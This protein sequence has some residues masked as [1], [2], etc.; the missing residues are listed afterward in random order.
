MNQVNKN[1]GDPRSIS[2]FPILLVNF[3]GTMG[4]SIVLPFLVFLVTRFGGNALIFGL[5]AAMY[6]LFQLIGSP[7]LGRWSDI[8][9]R[10]RVLFLSQAGT[11]IAWILFLIALFIPITI[12]IEIKSSLFGMFIITIPLVILFIA[13][14][15]DG[16]TGGNVSVANAYVA[17]ITDEKMRSANFGKMAVSSNLG[18]I[19]G[20]ALAGLLGATGYGAVIPVVA[21]ILISFIALFMISILLKESRPCSIQPRFFRKSVRK[22]FGQEISECR[23]S[24]VI[25][26]IP[27]RKILQVKNVPYMLLMYFIIFLGF[28][29]FYTSFPIHS[30]TALNWSIA[31]LGIFFSV[32]SFFMTIVQ[33]PVLSRV[34]KIV[35]EPWLILIGNLILGTNFIL[36]MSYDTRVI[37]GAAAL[38][39]VGNGLMWPSV[40]SILS[41]VAGDKYQGSI[42]GFAG[43]V[44]SFSSIIGLII[45]GLLYETI[46]VLSFI[47]SAVCIYV[48][49]IFSFH[50]RSSSFQN[51]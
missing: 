38:F 31:E 2:L 1:G 17:D 36:L 19:V 49:F 34:S 30:A 11:T 13:R 35:S 41:K 29:I 9:G 33:G 21:A 5:M 39:A 51:Y 45:G 37:Y 48:A 27:F 20:P 15:L 3:I 42:Q 26:K 40:L 28:N 46:G 44:G 25:N 4:F 8:Y 7:V 12:L 24:G 6:P 18:F 43:S 23:D 32:L 10:K 14:A 16:I 47:I 22:V 50:L